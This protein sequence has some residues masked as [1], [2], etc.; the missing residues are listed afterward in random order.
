MTRLRKETHR[1]KRNPKKKVQSQIIHEKIERSSPK[2]QK[3]MGY[4]IGK[5]G[6]LRKSQL[7]SGEGNNETFDSPKKNHQ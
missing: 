6:V 4:I 5:E 7:H 1:A 2:H 3:K